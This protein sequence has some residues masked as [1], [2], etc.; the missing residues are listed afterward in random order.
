MTDELLGLLGLA[1]KA[2]KLVLGEEGTIE[3]ALAHQLRLVFIAADAAEGG[4][5]KVARCAEAGNA[6]WV[7]LPLD[8]VQLGSAVGRA[9][10]AALGITDVGFAAAIAGKLSQSD[11]TAYGELSQRLG[12]KAAKTVRRRKEKQQRKKAQEAKSRKPWAGAPR[13]NRK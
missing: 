13:E 3:A 10:C 2:G 1:K 7:R 6:P 9:S 12:H 11:P 8:K 4:A 5:Q